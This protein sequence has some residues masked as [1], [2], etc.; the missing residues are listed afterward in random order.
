MT[1]TIE[2]Q[3]VQSSGNSTATTTTRSVKSAARLSRSNLQRNKHF[4]YLRHRNSHTNS[5]TDTNN[6]IYIETEESNHDRYKNDDD[7]IDETGKQE[8]EQQREEQHNPEEPP[9]ATRHLHQMS[10]LGPMKQ[11]LATYFNVS[12]ANNKNTN[13]S[14]STNNT[15]IHHHNVD[16]NTDR[17]ARTMENNSKKN[18]CISVPVTPVKSVLCNESPIEC[19]QLPKVTESQHQRK[20]RKYFSWLNIFNNGG[21]SVKQSS[22]CENISNKVLSNT[23]NNASEINEAIS[24][25]ISNHERKE[26]VANASDK[27]DN[28]QLAR[29][30]A[31]KSNVK[32]IVDGLSKEVQ[33]DASQN[34]Y[35]CNPLKTTD[36][37]DSSARRECPMSTEKFREHGRNLIDYISN[38]LDTIDK[39]RV[40]PLNIEPGYLRSLLEVDAPKEGEKFEDIMKDFENHIMCGITHWQHPR[41]H[42]YFPAGNAYASILADMLSDAIGCVGFSWVSSLSI[43]I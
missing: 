12:S 1:T 30:H 10:S 23:N 25:N 7:R 26:S 20:Q 18:K 15:P 40:T 31:K 32:I 4:S 39:R 17:R 3:S 19:S 14:N 11:F 37:L 27:S 35:T 16:Q 22:N 36:Q 13:G 9:P 2:K 42:A 5:A 6:T 43:L 21:D 38:Y 8:Q 41:F 33:T 28:R 24:S 34:E 29:R